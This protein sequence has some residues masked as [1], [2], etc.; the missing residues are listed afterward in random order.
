MAN[1]LFPNTE[2]AQRQA[3]AEFRK[4]GLGQ[5]M[6]TAE[7][8]AAKQNRRPGETDELR[9]MGMRALR[10]GILKGTQSTPIGQFAHS[11]NKFGAGRMMKEAALNALFRELGP[12]GSLLRG[13][14]M[15]SG[16]GT[17]SDRELQA[18]KEFLEAH[19]FEVTDKRDQTP[20]QTAA[21]R[22]ADMMN[23]LGITPQDAPGQQQQT[24]AWDQPF[25]PGEAEEMYA[26]ELNWMSVNNS[27]NVHSIAYDEDAST[28]Y[29]RYL[30]G[31]AQSR[32]GVGPTYA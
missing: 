17:R 29:V 13:V 28:M 9:Q 32:G 16:G 18:A 19:G 10:S 26:P 14:L 4:T 23:A 31:S 24:D 8:L 3:R 7:G 6:A 22:H 25:D 30:G 21:E 2:A 1:P 27:S 11:V 5:L 20:G 15:P 12:V